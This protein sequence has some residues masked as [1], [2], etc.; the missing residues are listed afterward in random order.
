MNHREQPLQIDLGRVV[1]RLCPEQACRPAQ[2]H[3]PH[4]HHLD[5]G[6]SAGRP[7]PDLHVVGLRRDHLPRR[8]HPKRPAHGILAFIIGR[9]I[10][11]HLHRREI[12]RRHVRVRSRRRRNDF[13]QG[14][15]GLQ[16]LDGLPERGPLQPARRVRG[17]H[18]V[19][20]AQRM[21]VE[22]RRR[23]VGQRL[24][25]PR[26]E[27]IGIRPARRTRRQPQVLVVRVQVEV[28]GKR[29]TRKDER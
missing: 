12:R 22:H 17:R 10:V 19:G 13:P 3:R 6:P 20:A 25:R 2:R 4:H 27:I 9:G 7:P 21:A 29:G 18:G 16:S 11:P 5:I 26:P 28:G 8:R 24:A 1:R 14:H 23:R 15:V